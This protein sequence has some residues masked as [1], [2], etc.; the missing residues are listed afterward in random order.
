MAWKL[1]ES[2]ACEK[3]DAMMAEELF[4]LL[5]LLFRLCIFNNTEMASIPNSIG[6]VSASHALCQSVLS[7]YLF[8]G[9]C[10]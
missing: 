1:E 8:T 10:L 4:F 9:V 6:Y 7:A 5:V 2:W 3:K